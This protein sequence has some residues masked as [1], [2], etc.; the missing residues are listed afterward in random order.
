MT[1]VPMSAATLVAFL[2]LLVLDD[3]GISRLAIAAQAPAPVV[4]GAAARHVDRARLMRDLEALASSRFAGRGAGTS[5]GMKARQWIVEQFTTLG[6]APA[7]SRG[8]LH[9]FMV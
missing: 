9:P 7:G 2:S 5:G 8:Y 1:S 3:R 4:P 6:L